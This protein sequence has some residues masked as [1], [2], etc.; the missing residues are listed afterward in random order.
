MFIIAANGRGFNREYRRE[1][2]LFRYVYFFFLVYYSALKLSEYGECWV[3]SSIKKKKKTT[4]IS[5][6]RRH[7]A[8][9]YSWIANRS[10]PFAFFSACGQKQLRLRFFRGKDKR[11]FNVFLHSVLARAIVIFWPQRHCVP[12]QFIWI[13]YHSRKK[14]PTRDSAFN[15]CLLLNW[16]Y[17]Y[18]ANN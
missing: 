1:I 16:C 17:L 5:M 2:L 4:E 12:C 6:P 11:A 18:R 10:F 15:F 7:A 13:F 14:S 9:L 8:M 3:S